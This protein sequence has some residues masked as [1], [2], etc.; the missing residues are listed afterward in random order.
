MCGHYICYILRYEIH[1][2]MSSTFTERIVF[3]LALNPVNIALL[4]GIVPVLLFCTNWYNSATSFPVHGIATVPNGTAH[5]SYTI[6]VPYTDTEYRTTSINTV[7]NS[8]VLVQLF[9]VYSKKLIQNVTCS[10]PIVEA[11]C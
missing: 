4:D 6:P 8:T 11:Q 1:A 10:I 9:L 5:R 3:M 7:L 2:S